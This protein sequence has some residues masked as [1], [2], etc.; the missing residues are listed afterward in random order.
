MEN[1]NGEER[2]GRRNDKLGVWIRL[3]KRQK[4]RCRE[5]CVRGAWLTYVWRSVSWRY[6]A[7]VIEVTH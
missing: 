2:K 4:L 1:V 7:Q 3:T 6:S 5:R